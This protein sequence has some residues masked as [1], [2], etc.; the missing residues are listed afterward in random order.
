MCSIPRQPERGQIGFVHK[1]E[2]ESRQKWR[3]SVSK[4]GYDVL[5]DNWLGEWDDVQVCFQKT[6]EAIHLPDLKPA[7]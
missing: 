6:G 1:P 7:S 2:R 3:L 4:W 5:R